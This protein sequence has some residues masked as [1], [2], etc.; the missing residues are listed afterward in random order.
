MHV[1]LDWFPCHYHLKQWYD[2]Q[3]TILSR[4]SVSDAN[5]ALEQEQVNFHTELLIIKR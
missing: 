2:M 3:L 5:G 1:H 4:A